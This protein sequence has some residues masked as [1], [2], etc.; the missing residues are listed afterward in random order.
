MLH[1]HY[2]LSGIQMSMVFQRLAV[3]R[4]SGKEQGE[5]GNI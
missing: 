4:S 5:T 1:G 3:W 2:P